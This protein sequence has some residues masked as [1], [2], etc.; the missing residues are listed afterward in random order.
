LSEAAHLLYPVTKEQGARRRKC[1]VVVVDVAVQGLVHSKDELRHAAKSPSRVLRS[2]RSIIRLQGLRLANWFPCSMWRGNLVIWNFG[3]QARPSRF[4]PD[5]PAR[6]NQEEGDMKT[7]KTVLAAA[8]IAGSATV[9]MA[10]ASGGAAGADT[11]PDR[12]NKGADTNPSGPGA[13]PRAGSTDAT[14]PAGQAKSGTKGMNI[15]PVSGTKQSKDS[16]T[17]AMAPTGTQ[18]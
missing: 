2:N 18:K 9:A 15:A 16:S 14:T 11:N 5:A 6:L 13:N 8:F 3:T 1:R 7:L 12:I 10:Q 4:L 17:P